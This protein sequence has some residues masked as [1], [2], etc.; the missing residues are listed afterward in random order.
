MNFDGFY[1][2]FSG[3][4]KIRTEPLRPPAKEALYRAGKVTHSFYIDYGT[5]DNSKVEAI[6]PTHSEYMYGGSSKL[7]GEDDLQY[8]NGTMINTSDDE[9]VDSGF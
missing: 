5:Q 2:Q 9:E 1:N 6:N 8:I 3:L 7:L 4:N